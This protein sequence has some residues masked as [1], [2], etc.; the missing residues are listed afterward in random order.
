MK[1]EAVIGIKK[2]KIKK[3]DLTFYCL[4]LAIPLINLAVFYFYANANSFLLGLKSYD[5]STGSFVFE[6]FTA[7]KQ[8]FNDLSSKLIRISFKNSVLVYFVGLLI[9]MPLSLFF[10]YYIFKK[11][12]LSGFIRV[13][14]YLPNII[15]SIV[16]I[17]IFKFFVERFIPN[18]TGT[19]GLL[20][21]PQTAQPIIL[22]YGVIV[23][24]GGTTLIYAGSMIGISDAVLEA[25]RLDRANSWQEFIYVVIP[26][27]WPT[28]TTFVVTGLAGLF[29]SQMYLFDVYGQAADAKLY[30][31]GYFLYSRTAA[32][33]FSD[34]PYLSAFGI[35]MTA[36][37][38]PITFGVRW[39]LNRFGPSVE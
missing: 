20:G 10:S 1:N 26:L 27:I 14:L 6:G 39:L 36:I 18:I 2:E 21:N 17:V 9:T 33:V 7:F 3:G 24:F 19:S 4:I 25:A 29:S 32:N 31:V 15:A 34:Y 12:P 13:M 22:F 23:G 37:T 11:F 5:P 38:V 8:A 35:Y 30:T 28:F 16:L